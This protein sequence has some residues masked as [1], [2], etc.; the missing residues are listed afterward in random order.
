MKKFLKVSGFFAAILCPQ[1]CLAV[2]SAELYTSTAYRY[3]RFEARTYFPAGDGVVGAFFLWKDGSEVPG[4]FWNELDFEKIGAD[5]RLQS[6]A[7][8]GNPAEVH[9]A[10]HA[11]QGLC[12]GYHTYAFEWTPNTIR[13]L[14]DGTA[15]RT[16][17]GATAKA[18][19]DNAMAMQIHFNI[20]PGDES[21]GGNFNPSILPVH[22]YI[23][24]V[25]YSA[26]DTVGGTFTL[27]WREDFTGA[28]LPTGW[29][30]GDWQSVKGKSTHAPQNVN[31]I[32]GFAVLSLTAD[33]AL[34]PAGAMPGGA[35]GAGGSMAG[36]A[37]S[38]GTHASGGSGN[39]TAGAPAVGGA[40][41]S[42][43]MGGSPGSAGSI[44]I[45]GSPGST[46]TGGSPASTGTAGTP[47]STGTG[48]SPAAAGG[49]ATPGGG[50]AAPGA[51]GSP[52]GVAGTGTVPG[53][54]VSGTS[55]S[56]NGSSGST[57]SDGCSFGPAPARGAFWWMLG[58]PALA[59]LRRRASRAKAT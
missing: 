54:G 13:W 20:W 2:G 56:S 15:V 32:N 6:N 46:G 33:N 19:A 40:P 42:A 48:G 44:G 24:W 31:L 47:G 37:G 29:V 9:T 5:C 52:S 57:S 59:W 10:Q 38:G 45:S 14:L 1:L 34:G 55:G 22:Q 43:G 17:T 23:D 12:A 30:A 7:F 41:G 50:G 16:E 11:S 8:Y 18:F 4:T 39:A 36:T 51:S 58:I 53:G 28:T 25:Q 26:Y 35:G 21:F 3:G 49:G 27:S